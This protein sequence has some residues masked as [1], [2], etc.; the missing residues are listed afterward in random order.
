MELSMKV[1]GFKICNMDKG[2]NSG[3]MDHFMKDNI[4]LEKNMERVNLYGLMGAIISGKCK[5]IICMVQVNMCGQIL[6][7]IQGNGQ[8]IKGKNFFIYKIKNLHLYSSKY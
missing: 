8:K 5:K 7:I 4:N 6:N 1:N 3:L 2:R